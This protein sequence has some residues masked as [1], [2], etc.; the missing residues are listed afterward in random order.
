MS[1]KLKLFALLLAALVIGG[2]VFAVSAL[3]D[4]DAIAPQAGEEA[5]AARR[6]LAKRYCLGSWFLKNG[7]PALLVGTIIDHT[8][9]V[10]VVQVEDEYIN[11][12]TPARWLVNEE[13]VSAA[14][15]F[16]E[17]DGKVAS[18]ETLK[19]EKTWNAK[20]TVYAVYKV[21]VEGVTAKAVLAVNI[22]DL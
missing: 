21:T 5:Q 8:P 12:L 6:L 4:E 15:L 19:V 13:I 17:W 11:V 2:T 10:T 3:P 18:M 7:A 20:V 1:S 22:Y 9:G 16:S 14:E